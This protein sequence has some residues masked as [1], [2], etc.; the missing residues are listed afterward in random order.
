MSGDV[1][2]TPIALRCRGA[3]HVRV[4]GPICVLVVSDVG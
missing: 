1:A 4:D 3:A 2:V